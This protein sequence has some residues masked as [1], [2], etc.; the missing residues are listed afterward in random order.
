M[1]ARPFSD[2]SY[3]KLLGEEKLAGSRC[4]KCNALFVPPKPICTKCY[5]TQMEWVEMSG[6]GKLFAFTVIT[7]CP[8]AMAAEGYSRTNPYCTGVVE[9]DEG[10]RVDARIEGVDATKPET[11]R[12]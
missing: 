7:V 3:E 5:G 6:K 2:I 8:P 12:V 4:A 10:A 1:D 9:L 11:I